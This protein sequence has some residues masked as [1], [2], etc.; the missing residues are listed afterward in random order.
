MV[1]FALT[2]IRFLRALRRAWRDALFRS[3]FYLLLL[4][5]FSGT[6]FFVT[7]E[8][9]RWVDAFY[10]SVVT[11]TT[12]GYGDL[13][14]VTDVGKIFT[15]IYLFTGMGVVITVVT[16]LARAMFNEPPSKHDD[17]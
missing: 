16:R 2:I 11:L 5:L 1:S 10:L 3:S 9:L 7:V 6:M 15:V 8:G 13:H 4:I 12:L 17:P 14:P